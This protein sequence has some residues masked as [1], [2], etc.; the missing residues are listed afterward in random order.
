M[1]NKT[2]Y[3]RTLGFSVRRI[4]WD[5]IAVILVLALAT[6]GFILAEK[7]LDEAIIGLVIG[8]I[9]GIIIAVIM[10]RFVSYKL[11]AGQIAMMTRA[12]VDGELPDDVIGEGKR[13]VKARFATVAAYFAI[14]GAIK[15]IF[16]QLGRGITKVG[17]SLGGDTG[18]AVG[19]AV[20]S[21]ISTLVS[22]LCDCCLGWVFLREG[23]KA[24]KATCEGAVLF[25]K[26]GKTLL[27]NMG[28]IFGIGL[29]S[30][31]VIGGA[32]SALFYFIISGHDQAFSGIYEEIAEMA[33]TSD[34]AIIKILQDPA[35]VPIAI[36]VILGIIVWAII[37]SAFIRPFVLTGVLRNYLESGMEDIPSEDSFAMLDSRSAKFRKLHASL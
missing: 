21:A 12:I 19:G 9:V 31:V 2:I 33:A 26:H 35:A 11:K 30:L 24:A 1:D 34:D 32:F 17:E 8:A 27:K 36:A 5:V 25:F 13:T 16:N 23:V 20:S 10:M 15:G 6:L 22:Y 29:G 7:L 14:T 28:R 18:S 3:G 4:L 37:H